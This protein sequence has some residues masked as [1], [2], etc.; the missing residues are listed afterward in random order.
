MLKRQHSADGKSRHS[1]AWWTNILNIFLTTNVE[2]SGPACMQQTV[3]ALLPLPRDARCVIFLTLVA[4]KT[5]AH[6]ARPTAD[7]AATFAVE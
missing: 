3:P 1:V 2:E 5:L 7:P 6:Q 4:G